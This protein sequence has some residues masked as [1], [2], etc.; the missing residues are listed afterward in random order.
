MQQTHVHEQHHAELH[1]VIDCQL[2]GLLLVQ[3][4]QVSL[5]DNLSVDLT[6]A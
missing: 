5:A 4:D 6:T 1:V 3:Y 2:N